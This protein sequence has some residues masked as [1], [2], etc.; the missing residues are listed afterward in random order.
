LRKFIAEMS[1]SLMA[2]AIST[3][4]FRVL[5]K[6]ACIKVLTADLNQIDWNGVDPGEVSILPGP[7]VSPIL[8]VNTFKP[9]VHS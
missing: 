9:R 3:R 8:H 2:E 6:R 5:A 1:Y 7:A 4:I